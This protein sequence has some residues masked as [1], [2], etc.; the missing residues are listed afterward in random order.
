MRPIYQFLYQCLYNELAWAY[1]TV[2]W[3]VSLGRWHTWQ[4]AALPFIRG[5]N[6]LEV[7]FGTGELL[8]QMQDPQRR[9]IGL[10]PSPAMHRVAAEKHRH[11]LQTVP[12]V[13]GIAQRL[14]FPDNTF[15]T[16]LCTFPAGYILDPAAH[17]EFTRCL[18]P[19]GRFVILEVALVGSHLL[20]GLLFHLAFPSAP[21]SKQKIVAV[22]HDA[23][24]SL[25]EHLVGKESV[26]PLVIVAEKKATP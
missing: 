26:R 21:E 9:V 14:P 24:F 3:V 13:Q 23:G 4:E 10:E 17:Q 2:S 19:G 7:G 16:V 25:E 12:R 22:A 6:V 18:R 20:W 11:H 1:D 8:A 5:N 15:D